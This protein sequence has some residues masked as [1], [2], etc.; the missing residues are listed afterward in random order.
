MPVDFNEGFFQELSR[1]PAVEGLV[2]GV[3]TEIMHDMVGTAPENTGAYKAGFHV[4]VKHQQR[5]VA[6]I[7]NN[8]PKTLIIQAKTGH[9][10]R[11]LQRA[12]KASRG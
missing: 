1:S 9:M 10:V 8:D 11:S 12:K 5:S 3:A 7:V 6:L 4:E 2:V